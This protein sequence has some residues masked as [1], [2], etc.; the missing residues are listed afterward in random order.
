[1]VKKSN[2][3]SSKRS[4]MKLERTFV[5]RGIRISPYRDD[6]PLLLWPFAMPCCE[7]FPAHN[8]GST[9]GDG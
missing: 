8:R 5:Y 9:G 6:G 2:R 3:V 4:S 1:M 7:R